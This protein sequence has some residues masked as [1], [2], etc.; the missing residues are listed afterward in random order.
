[1]RFLLVVAV[2]RPLCRQ[3]SADDLENS[4]R[5]RGDPWRASWTV[6]GVVGPWRCDWPWTPMPASIAVARL[7][8]VDVIERGVVWFGESADGKFLAGRPLPIPRIGARLGGQC[9]DGDAAAN[10]GVAVFR[11]GPVPWPPSTMTDNR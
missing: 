1:L 4:W 9:V 5:V 2:H 10:H 11:E 6:V 7:P 8:A 3:P